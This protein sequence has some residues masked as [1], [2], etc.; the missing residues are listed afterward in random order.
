MLI[1]K[2]KG[3]NVKVFKFYEFS[4]PYALIAVEDNKDKTLIRVEEKDK[5]IYTAIKEYDC[6]IADIDNGFEVAECT[7]E[8]ALNKFKKADIENCKTEEEK[9]KEFEGLLTIVQ[10]EWNLKINGKVVV[11]LLIDGELL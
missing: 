11:L 5:P 6:E 3:M 8:Y 1:M 10:G 9:E 4:D 2:N 7:K